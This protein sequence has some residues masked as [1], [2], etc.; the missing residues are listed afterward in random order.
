MRAAMELLINEVM[1]LGGERS[2]LRAKVFGGAAVVKAFKAGV[3]VGR[4]N[5]EFIRA[6]L[7]AERIPIDA[8]QLGGTQPLEVRFTTD[9]AKVRVRALE[10]ADDLIAEEQRVVRPA[11]PPPPVATDADVDAI[12][13]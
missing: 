4:R 9:T 3:D 1:K 7:A 12:L 10:A 8:E 5:A 6:F 2:R 13:F 11:P